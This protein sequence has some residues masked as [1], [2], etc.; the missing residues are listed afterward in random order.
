MR[1][2]LKMYFGKEKFLIKRLTYF[3][4][5]EDGKMAGIKSKKKE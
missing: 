5:E 1:E 4:R 3:Q 2:E